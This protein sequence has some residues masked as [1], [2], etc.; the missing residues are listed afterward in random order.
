MDFPR[1]LDPL[2]LEV[3]HD[4]ELPDYEP[5]TAPEYSRGD[6]ET[7]LQ[8]FHLRQVDRKLQTFVPYGPTSSVSYKVTARGARLF[9]KKAELD[10]WRIPS[11]RKAEEHVASIWF[12]NDGPLPWRPRAHFDHEAAQ[13]LSTHCM[14]SRNF[15]DWTVAVGG[16]TYTWRLGSHPVALEL[17]ETTSVEVIA[18]FIFSTR[19]MTASG[20]AE[21]GDL[22]IYHHALSA[23]MDGIEKIMCGLVV[24]IAHFRKMGR[25]YWNEEKDLPIRAT[26]FSGGHVASHRASITSYA[27]I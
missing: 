8:T 24:A 19:G 9:S 15:H 11:W 12:D 13:G 5:N 10:I 16:A 14:E 27:T 25:Y 17:T 2:D 23:D 22:S 21:A 3:A 6:Y 1:R 7:P 4:D 18:R 20:G 26:S